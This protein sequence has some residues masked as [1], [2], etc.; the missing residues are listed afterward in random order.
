MKQLYLKI[1]LV[2]ISFGAQ[3]QSLGEE[4]NPFESLK[5]LVSLGQDQAA[6]A[7]IQSMVLETL[8]PEQQSLWY[9]A[10]GVVAYENLDWANAE[11]SLDIAV[12]R[13]PLLRPLSLYY[14]GLSQKHLGK[15]QL[16]KK[17]FEKALK[18]KPNR[19]M[20][21]EVRYA[22]G[23]LAYAQGQWK[24]AY[25]HYRYLQRR[26]KRSDKYPWILKRLVQV[27][28]KRK[29][30]WRACRWAR[31]LYRNFPSSL[32]AKNWGIDLQNVEV[33][34]RKLG[35][36]A[37][38]KDQKRRIRR[39]QWA[40]ASVRAREE[41]EILKK[42]AIN[43]AEYEV[44]LLLANFFV[45][46]GFVS[47]ALVVLLPYYDEKLKDYNYLMLVGKAA[48]KSGEFQ[49]AVS[50]YY[51]AH[52]IA[53]RRSSY[54]RNALFK[55][56][57][58]SYQ[59]QDYDGAFRKFERYMKYYGHHRQARSA[60]WH[61][62][63]L[64]YLKG[65]YKGAIASLKP[66]YKKAKRHPWRWRK[67]PKEKIQYWMAMSHFRLK[68]F[69]QARDLF[70]GL[71]EEAP[72]SYYSQASR[73]RL[74]NLPPPK[75]GEIRGLANS[76]LELNSNGV[77]RAPPIKPSQPSPLA[78]VEPE[79][80]E[81][82]ADTDEIGTS[83][84]PVGKDDE[85][86]ERDEEEMV[87]AS[88]RFQ[89]H[90]KRAQSLI[91]LGLYDWAKEELYEIEKKTKRKS[92]RLQLIQA[93][94]QIG[95]YHRSAFVAEVYFSKERHKSGIESSR[96]LWLSAYPQAFKNI[97]THYSEAF[98][99]EKEF[100]WGLMRAESRY[101]KDISSPVGARGL[102]QL[103][104]HTATQVS[105]LLGDEVFRASQLTE[106]GVNVRLGTRYLQRLSKKFKGQLPLM[107]AGYN[108]GPHRVESWL[109]QFGHLEMDEF[110]EH[111]PFKETRK[112]VKKVTRNYGV[113]KA[114]SGN[115]A[116]PIAWLP[117]S[118]EIPPGTQATARET[119]EKL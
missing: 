6:L 1:F 28:L 64:K 58:L 115:N 16:A 21:Y 40:G 36:L 17:T 34:N 38:F 117:N 33:E 39:F 18:A 68:E 77:L 104:T 27:D 94:E 95:V 41:I 45:N 92:D 78:V 29:K 51:R 96:D 113:Y 90:L 8:T 48:A 60:R 61:M 50:A 65:D 83:E 69:R 67:Y 13:L 7:Q 106:P 100:I 105:R 119:W 102:M 107:A 15:I 26:W 56:A 76:E 103:M 3:A 37:S 52:L 22:L 87:F 112:Y 118:I 42:R 47:E 84:I 30:R 99:I 59:F 98:G 19:F 62:G 82:D 14:L 25:R 53:K 91:Q 2:F 43:G 73:S 114:L 79:D 101:R 55:A 71:I 72:L 5:S 57:F 9:F 109:T 20:R 11:K 81:A 70:D 88:S 66:I 89:T 32:A 75:P 110:I 24:G 35:C 63:W 10:H 108:A 49:T 116:T 93:Y 23:E 80:S 111:I 12:D 97:V 86:V 74:L 85:G 31:N 54:A 46:E 44:G 4:V